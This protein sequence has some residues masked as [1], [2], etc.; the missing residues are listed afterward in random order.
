MFNAK[1]A[2]YE[3]LDISKNSG[4][5]YKNTNFDK[6][7]I[8]ANHKSFMSSLNIPI[9]EEN[10]K[11]STLY[12]IPKFQKNQYLDRYIP[13][14]STCSTKELSITMTN[15]LHAVKGGL[16]SY[17]DKLYSRGN[18][19]QKHRI[20]GVMVSVLASSAVDRGFDPRSGQTKDYKIGI[21]CFSAKHAELRRKS[22][23]CLARNQ[24]G[25][26]CPNGVIFL[27]ADCCF[28]VLAL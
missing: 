11:L 17:C 10:C 6:E 28:S 1:R 2:I 23:D 19:N 26:M 12:W 27:P 13:G 18:I 21:C 20:G 3:E 14:S 24:P 7:D 16:L 8:L 9:Y 4:K 25:I 15:I 22:K 5:S